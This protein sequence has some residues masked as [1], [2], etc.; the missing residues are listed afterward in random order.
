MRE[1]NKENC[2][3]VSDSVDFFFFRFLVVVATTFDFLPH[4]W[5]RN[6]K[7]EGKT[8]AERNV[9]Q[10]TRR[11]KIR[12]TESA[13]I[14]RM[15]G[16]PKKC[17]MKRNK[18]HMEFMSKLVIRFRFDKLRMDAWWNDTRSFYSFFVLFILNNL[19]CWNVGISFSA[20][21]SHVL[22]T[23]IYIQHRIE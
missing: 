11:N 2:F 7:Q 13:K 18:F 6:Q 16:E 3:I 22:H 12:T 20:I 5:L 1:R 23:Q 14:K 21:L 4:I 15:N 9:C 17:L 10:S 19:P 8:A